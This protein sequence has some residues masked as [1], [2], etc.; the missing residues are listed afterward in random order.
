LLFKMVAR[1]LLLAAFGVVC[2]AAAPTGTRSVLVTG[3]SGRTGKL[4]YAQLKARNDMKVKALV[5]ASADAKDNA[6][7]ALNCTKCDASEGIFYG[8]VTDPSTLEAPM[9]GVDTV[10]IC[11]SVGGHTTNQTVMKAV[12]FIGVENQVAALAMHSD[13]AMGDK[14]V[15][16]LSSMETTNPHP[17]PFEGGRVLFWKLNAE[18]FLG[19]SGIGSSIVKP[20]GIEGAYGRGGKELIVGHNDKLKGIMSSVISRADVAAVMV[21]TIIDRDTS[22]RFD[23]CVGKGAPTTDLAAL[24]NTAR[25][26]WLKKH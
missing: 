3:A 18:A 20:C 7:K 10:A 14:R 9:A 2:A 21:Q 6:R 24:L 19:S 22:L 8:D 12:E 17:L 5:R 1:T 16:L 11:V 23:L 25:N 26:A 4:L 15:V 13:V